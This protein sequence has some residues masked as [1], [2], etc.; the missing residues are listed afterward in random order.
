MS[1]CPVGNCRVGD[2]ASKRCMGAAGGEEHFQEKGSRVMLR[3]QC[4][5]GG[6]QE[7]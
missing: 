5:H 2:A 1:K 7:D 4:G 6:H 3:V